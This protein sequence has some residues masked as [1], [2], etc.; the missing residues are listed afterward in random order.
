MNVSI[1]LFIT[2]TVYIAVMLYSTFYNGKVIPYSSFIM[3]PAICCDNVISDFPNLSFLTFSISYVSNHVPYQFKGFYTVKNDSNIYSFRG[4]WSIFKNVLF[5][6]SGHCHNLVFDP[7]RNV[8][9]YHR[10]P[11]FYVSSTKPVY[12][13]LVNLTFYSR[14]IIS[15]YKYCGTYG[16]FIHDYLCP[17]LMIPRNIIQ[18]SML[19]LPSTKYNIMVKSVLGVTERNFAKGDGSK[20][21]YSKELYLP[22][23]PS[24]GCSHF[25]F[26]AKQL[27][28]KVFN[29]FNLSNIENTDYVIYNRPSRTSR[30]IKN[31]N[32]IYHFLTA[33]FSRLNWKIL[34]FD[35][36]PF[37]EKLKTFTRIKLLLCY[38]GS[39]ISNS[40]AMKSFSG[41]I[42]ISTERPLV[43]NHR[44]TLCHNIWIFMILNPGQ[45]HHSRK[46]LYINVSVLV[47]PLKEMLYAFEHNKWLTNREIEYKSRLNKYFRDGNYVNLV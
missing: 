16:H 27:K 39:I 37:E 26:L 36:L 23:T 9:M 47:K 4:H 20:F 13:V 14:V 11:F 45:G 19:L 38:S 5:R 41:I 30:H 31:F 35:D 29:R 1:N 6:N 8:I 32:E 46:Q 2:R 3:N 42:S 24:P 12:E 40:F 17:I 34:Q 44:E 18:R 43:Y 15:G 33:N 21:S 28:E 7:R 22:N 25:S 10:I